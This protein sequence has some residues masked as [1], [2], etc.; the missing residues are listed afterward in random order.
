MQTFWKKWEET[1]P[2]EEQWE[3]IKWNESK[4]VEPE[5]DDEDGQL[6]TIL[7]T[8]TGRVHSK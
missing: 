2:W 6:N 5:L 1:R 8:Q 3:S 7:E 4:M